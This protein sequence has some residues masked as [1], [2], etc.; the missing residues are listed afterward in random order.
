MGYGYFGGSLSTPLSFIPSSYG[1]W[2]ANFDLIAYFT[3][4]NAIPSNPAQDFLT[5]SFNVKVGF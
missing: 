1:A 2:S 5:A 4:K 3:N